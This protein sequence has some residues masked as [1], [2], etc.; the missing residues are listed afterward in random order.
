MGVTFGNTIPTFTVDPATGLITFDRGFTTG[1]PTVGTGLPFFPTAGN[2]GLNLNL[3]FGGDEFNLT[4]ILRLAS[5][6]DEV[7]TVN[8][9]QITLSNAQQG[10]LT[11]ETDHDYVSG[12]NVTSN[13]LTPTTSTVSD[14]IELSVRPI[15]SA[16][17][18]YVFL[19]LYPLITQTDLTNSVTFTTF[20]GQPGGGGTTGGGASGTAVTNFI[21]LP[22][23]T[24]QSFATTVGVP[25][26][27]VVI[28]GGLA[29]I[30]REVHEA[31]VPIL[32]KIPILNRLFSAKGQ[33]INRDT[34]FI[35]A[36]PEIQM[37]DELEA[38]MR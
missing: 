24:S 21:T 7:R 30:D 11:V 27:G 19:E 13:T 10:F 31:G 29:K 25:D 5:K 32:D 17:R 2:T 33:L 18:H 12:Y 23:I 9:P 1:N 8:A 26:R 3:G 28:V 15:V 4:G 36:K 6:R 38:T 37:Q 22:I 14:I 16:D 34:L 35:M 20:T